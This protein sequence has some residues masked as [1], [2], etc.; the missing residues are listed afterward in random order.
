MELDTSK[1]SL[2]FVGLIGF[3]LLPLGFIW[4]INNLFTLNVEYTFLNW[5]SAMFVQ[6][7]IQIVIRSSTISSNASK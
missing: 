2:T 7:Y 1:A 6:F 4:S 5:V 3:S